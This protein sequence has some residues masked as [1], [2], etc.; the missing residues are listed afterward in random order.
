ML[1]LVRNGLGRKWNIPNRVFSS[2]QI[3]LGLSENKNCFLFYL[4][5]ILKPVFQILE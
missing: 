2:R 4:A 1:M 5:L 3:T